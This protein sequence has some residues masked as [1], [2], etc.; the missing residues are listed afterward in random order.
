MN[1][2]RPS[3]AF[4]YCKEWKAG[5]GLEMRLC[6]HLTGIAIVSIYRPIVSF[7][8]FAVRKSGRGPGIIYHM[9]DVEGREK[10]ERT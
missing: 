10:V 5:Q 2:S 1:Y 4:L 7:P 3:P 8:S 9:S 6:T